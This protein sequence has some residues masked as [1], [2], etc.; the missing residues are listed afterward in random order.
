MPTIAHVDP[1]NVM[2]CK[3]E[4]TTNTSKEQT[5]Q[6]EEMIKKGAALQEPQLRI[7]ASVPVTV[8]VGSFVSWLNC[9]IS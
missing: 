5:N 1:Q 6:M 2:I 7:A 8:Y 4:C 9:S 3:L